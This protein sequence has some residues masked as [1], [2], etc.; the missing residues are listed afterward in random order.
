MPQPGAVEELR[1]AARQA[2]YFKGVVRR[3]IWYAAVFS[4]VL[5]IALA[6][7]AAYI[8]GSVSEEDRINHLIEELARDHEELICILAIPPD[9][10]TPTT[11]DRCYERREGGE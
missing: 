9:D 5:T 10:R 8:T 1:E 2:Q 7:A 3:T 11:P 4:A 6:F